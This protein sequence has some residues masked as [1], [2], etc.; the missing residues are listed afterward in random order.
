M[1]PSMQDGIALSRQCEAVEI[2]TLEWVDWFNTRRLLEPIGNIPPA[3]TEGIY[4]AAWRNPLWPH[5]S[6]NQAS[7]KPG[8]VRW[9]TLATKPTDA[10]ID[11]A[12]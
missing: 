6:S 2:A 8:T 1:L 4:Y 9:Q 3:E 7:D 11:L 10:V 12:A 5:D